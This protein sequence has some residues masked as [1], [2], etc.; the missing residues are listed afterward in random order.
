MSS[1]H[2]FTKDEHLVVHTINSL[3]RQLLI[4]IAKRNPTIHD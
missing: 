2:N 4:L 1:I 3:P